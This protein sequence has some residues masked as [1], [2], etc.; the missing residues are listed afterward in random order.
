MCL[1]IPGQIVEISDHETNLALADVSGVRRKVNVTCVAGEGLDALV[2]KWVLIHV[3]FAM[4]IID[5]AEA[6]KTMDTLNAL[7][8]AQ[9]EFEAMFESDRAM[10]GRT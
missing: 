1:G 10:E 9:E 7:G 4:A 8:E 6:K 5:E 3:G 2:G